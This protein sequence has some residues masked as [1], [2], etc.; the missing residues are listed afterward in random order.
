MNVGTPKP[1]HGLSTI[2]LH[3][4]SQYILLQRIIVPVL[5]R[6][7]MSEDACIGCTVAWLWPSMDRSSTLIR[8]KITLF[9]LYPMPVPFVVQNG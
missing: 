1:P 2:L 4:G 6:L 8:H 9:Q 3:R 5:L 7:E